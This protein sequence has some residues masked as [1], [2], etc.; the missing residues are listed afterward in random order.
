MTANEIKEYLNGLYRGLMY[1]ATFGEPSDNNVRK[2]FL[3]TILGHIEAVETMENK[4][5]VDSD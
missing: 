4:D 1:G 2:C 5:E 3:E